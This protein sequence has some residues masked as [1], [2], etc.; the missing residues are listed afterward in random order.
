MEPDDS[1]GEVVGDSGAAIE[2]RRSRYLLYC[3]SLYTTPVRLADIA[4]QVTVWET[5][6]RKDDR[7]R[8]IATERHRTYMSL[9]HDY[10]PELRDAGI[11]KYDQEGD[12]VSFGPRKDAL[13]DT[14][15]RYLSREL[16]TLLEAE[17]MVFDADAPRAL[18][19][20]LH[21]ALATSE[22]RQLLSLLLDQPEMTLEDAAIL[23]VDVP[24]DGEPATGMTDP[25]RLKT[26]LHHLHLPLFEDA[27]LV[28]YDAE[29]KQIECEPL[30]EPVREAIRSATRSRRIQQATEPNRCAQF[31]AE[32]ARLDEE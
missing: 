1:S 4:Y 28:T 23:L 8:D 18:P 12:M 15:E 32:T 16:D 20:D 9:Y 22:R 7:S 29:T 31:D 30:S 25:D 21:R 17:Q 11:V 19:D 13:T 6:T 3:L 27:G 5:V 10:L 2:D 14:L 26:R 24:T